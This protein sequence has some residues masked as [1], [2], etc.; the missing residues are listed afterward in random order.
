MAV[1]LSALCVGHP[2]LPGRFLVLISVRGWVDPRSIVRLEGLGK[3][4][5]TMTSPGIEP[6]TFQL[7]A[8]CLNPLRCLRASFDPGLEAQ[9]ERAVE[10]Q[11]Q[12][13]PFLLSSMLSCFWW[14]VI[15]PSLSLDI[16]RCRQPWLLLYSYLAVG[17]SRCGFVP[18]SEG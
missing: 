13:R 18:W 16:H 14:T 15:E 6:S 1:R 9:C 17:K 4:K 11:R 7:V 3:L 12:T 8:Q 5:N 2:L 10:K